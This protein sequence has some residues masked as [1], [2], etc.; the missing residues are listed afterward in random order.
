MTSEASQPALFHQ[1]ELTSSA[2]A[3]RA[4]TLAKLVLAQ[5]STA[6]VADFGATTRGLLASYDLALSSWKT[7]QLCLGGGLAVFSETWPRSGWML[8]GV[9]YE[10]PT[11]ERPTSETGFGLLPTPR[12]AKRGARNPKTAIESLK[13]RGRT[14][15]HKLEDALVILEGL[16]GIP[17]PAYVEWMMGFPPTW[18]ELEPSAT[19]SSRKSRS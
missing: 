1:E 10:V 17:S 4:K 19:P 3:S 12:A 7:S 11:L 18:T 14:K 8:G 9:A 5:A 2:A 13:R 15:P 16:T 6:S